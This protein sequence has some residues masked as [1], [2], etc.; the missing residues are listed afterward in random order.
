M[1]A[2]QVGGRAVDVV[3]GGL[4]RDQRDEVHDAPAANLDGLDL[5]M[6]PAGARAEARAQG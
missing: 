2:V 1:I 4:A 3:R 5:G 6:R